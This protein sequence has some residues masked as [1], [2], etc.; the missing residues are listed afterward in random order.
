M[1]LA[2][3]VAFQTYKHVSVPQ[4]TQISCGID[5]KRF[6]VAI[7]PV[8]NPASFVDCCLG[9][10]YGHDLSGIK[11]RISNYTHSFLWDVTTR[12]C[13]TPGRGRL[14]HRDRDKMDAN[15]MTI[16]SY[17]FSWMKIYEFRLKFFPN[18]PIN[19]ISS[20][21]Q[22]MAWRRPGDKPFSESMMVILLT[23]ICATRPRWVKLTHP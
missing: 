13:S 23:H 6:V 11:A 16:F 14:T 3:S 2:S 17:A 7:N 19:N 15:F 22:I 8:D 4:I 12:P 10:F 20:L 9:I 21:V 18:G 5:F 1:R